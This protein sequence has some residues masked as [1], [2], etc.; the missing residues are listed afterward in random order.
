MDFAHFCTRQ[1]CYTAQSATRRELK[2]PHMPAPRH[3]PTGWKPRNSLAT[4]LIA[5]ALSNPMLSFADDTEQAGGNVAEASNAID[6]TP[7]GRVARAIF[8]TAVVDR[9]P[10][11]QLSNLSHNVERVFFFSEL[12]GLDGE[13]VTH[14]W[15]Y[16]GQTMAEVTFKVGNGARWRVYSSKNLLPEWT[17]TWTVV[18]S[19][20]KGQALQT[21]SFEYTAE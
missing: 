7:S 3:F 20:E 15:Q 14:R 18:V 10:V 16:D 17:G 13:I 12:R 5:I 8:T 6:G 9:E 4:T 21:S 19:N 1:L 11:D 2:E